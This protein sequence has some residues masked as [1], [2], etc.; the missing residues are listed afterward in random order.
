[1]KRCRRPLLRDM[2]L[3]WRRITL[4]ATHSV[5]LM[6][7]P[8]HNPAGT[9]LRT[10]FPLSPWVHV[11]SPGNPD[12]V[13]GREGTKEAAYSIG[14]TAGIVT[15]GKETAGQIGGDAATATPFPS[16]HH[17]I[18]LL[19]AS[20]IG[21]RYGCSGGAGLC[22]GRLCRLSR[23]SGTSITPTISCRPSVAPAKHLDLGEAMHDRVVLL[24]PWPWIGWE[25]IACSKR[26]GKKDIR[27]TSSAVSTYPKY[28]S[29]STSAPAY[30][31]ENKVSSDGGT[32]F[33]LRDLE[34]HDYRLDDGRRGIWMRR[35]TSGTK[36]GF[37]IWPWKLGTAAHSTAPSFIGGSR[38]GQHHH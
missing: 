10:A 18:L 3:A 22:R 32:M 21:M 34:G 14:T 33:N 4:V 23:S 26:S 24:A 7:E 12:G 17:V 8:E 30:V 35:S 2:V 15:I 13:V 16:G 11:L 5:R 19:G 25:S 29:T 9:F 31:K 27:E 1:M 6:L 37:S 38:S 20:F 36:L 28:F